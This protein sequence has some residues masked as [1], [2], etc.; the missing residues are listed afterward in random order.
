MS[1][2]LLIERTRMTPMPDQKLRTT[3][4]PLDILSFHVTSTPQ[5]YSNGTSHLAIV[6]ILINGRPLLGSLEKD[7]PLDVLQLLVQGD[8]VGTFDLFTCSCG[9]AGCAGFHDQISLEQDGANVK[10]TLPKEGYEALLSTPE[11]LEPRLV[12]NFERT[13]YVQA[14][15][16]LE[17]DLLTLESILGP[18]ELFSNIT[19]EDTVSAVIALQT[20]FAD[21]RA[22][23]QGQ[24][25]RKEVF[26]DAFGDLA[27]KGIALKLESNRVY[28]MTTQQYAW[29][30]EYQQEQ[31]YD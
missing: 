31:G 20:L 9:V 14:L 8:F 10:W 4:A 30:V 19:G 26:F 13:G 21:S 29:A 2:V 23:Q 25:E 1:I 5:V 11:T 24:R 6:H 16:Q 7:S 18:I 17:Q 27:D 12:F 3:Q 28:W 22:Y 15:N